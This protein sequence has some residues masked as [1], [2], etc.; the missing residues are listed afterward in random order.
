M[1]DF[2][3]SGLHGSGWRYLKSFLAVALQ[4]ALILVIGMIYSALFKGL[5]LDQ[6]DNLLL[7]LGKY[8]IIYASAVMLMFKSL[9]LSKELV[10]VS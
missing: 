6:T 8:I 1:S 2:F 7:F 10:G 4:G 3:H 5:I 9:P